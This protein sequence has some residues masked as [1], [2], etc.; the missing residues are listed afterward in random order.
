MKNMAKITLY[1]L[2]F[3]WRIFYVLSLC[4]RPKQ[5]EFHQLMLVFYVLNFFPVLFIPLHCNS[6]RYLNNKN[7]KKR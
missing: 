2:L 6:N 5:Q 7:E 3:L 4:L 1:N